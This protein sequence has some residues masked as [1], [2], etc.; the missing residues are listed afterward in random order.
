MKTTPAGD[1]MTGLKWTRKTTV[2][3]S[4]ELKSV[5]ITVG[6]RT[7]ARLLTELD[8]RLRVNHKKLS[9]GPASKRTERNEQFEYIN[10]IRQSFLDSGDPVISVDTKKKELI[11]LFKNPG[12]A[13][14]KVATPVR[15]HD[16]RSEAKAMAAPY[17]VHDLGANQGHIFVGIS[18]DTPQFAVAAI[19]QW[20]KLDGS[21][22]Y[23]RSNRLLI[24]A[25]SGGSNSPRN[26]AWK[27]ELQNTL[28]SPHEL[29]VTV[30]HYPPG[31]SK[32]NPIEHLLFSQVSKN[33]A[34]EPLVDIDTMLNFIRTTKTVTG[35]QVRATLMEGDFQK[36]IKIPD[37]V[38]AT[39]N[40]I[41]H[42]ILPAWNYTI[43]PSASKK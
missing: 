13:W 6:A 38:M 7:V 30:C 1:P 15:D 10:A 5:G 16:F 42:E 35:L 28:S 29:E 2:K 4:Q 33:W 23:P 9:R 40:I 11:G 22:R 3:V 24:L 41:A 36:G 14:A 27:F 20:W 39:L 31:A 37:R 19:T 21:S 12:A 26:R 25:D 43:A 17:G 8:Y 18:H 32:W 34:G